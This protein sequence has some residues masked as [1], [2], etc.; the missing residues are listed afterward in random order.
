MMVRRWLWQ[1]DYYVPVMGFASSSEH[2]MVARLVST[3]T[4]TTRQSCGSGP[5]SYVS[6]FIRHAWH[7]RD[8]F[9]WKVRL[10]SP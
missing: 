6:Y 10:D 3:K 5:R 2:R 1:L 7:C 8:G 4:F 9:G